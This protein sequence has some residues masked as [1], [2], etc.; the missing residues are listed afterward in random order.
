M[1][2]HHLKVHPAQYAALRWGGKTFEFRRNDR[3]YVVGDILHLAEW[4]PEAA[5][6]TGREGTYRVTYVMG[7]GFGLP[8]GYCVMAVVAVVQP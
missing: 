3:G 7:P 6:Y 2:V 4:D 5:S 8:A 1:T